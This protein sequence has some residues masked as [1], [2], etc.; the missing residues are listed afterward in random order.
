M[1]GKG[2]PPWEH[3]SEPEK[4]AHLAWNKAAKHREKAAAKARPLRRQTAT[5]HTGSSN[6]SDSDSPA[7]ST[8]QGTSLN[9]LEPAAPPSTTQAPHQPD[10]ALY[11]PQQPRPPESSLTATRDLTASEL[12]VCG[13][14]AG[15]P[16]FMCRGGAQFNPPIAVADAWKQVRMTQGGLLLLVEMCRG[17][18]R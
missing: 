18:G 14:W 12:C 10:I 2:R 7:V 6:C 16:A 4:Q 17:A 9:P 3:M 13:T 1:G 15:G 11:A 8:L 5:S